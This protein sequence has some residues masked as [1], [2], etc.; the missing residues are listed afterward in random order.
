MGKAFYLVTY[1][2][3]STLITSI[4]L[5]NCA[6]LGVTKHLASH[7]KNARGL[8]GARWADH[9]QV[10]HIALLNDS[11]QLL[12]GV[13]ISLDIIKGDRAVLLH[14]GLLVVFLHFLV[15]FCAKC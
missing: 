6:L 4:E 15:G 5:K 2:V 9:D 7:T 14:K 10:G 1:D 3:N 13:V 8:A 11:L 12:D